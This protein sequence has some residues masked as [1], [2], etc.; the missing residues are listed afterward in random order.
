MNMNGVRRH[1]IMSSRKEGECFT[2]HFTKL[3]A[4]DRQ[5]N[6]RIKLV[7]GKCDMND[8]AACFIVP[9]DKLDPLMTFTHSMRSKR[10]RISYLRTM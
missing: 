6:W 4:N 10:C 7:P 2:Y 5:G 3:W 9:T 1:E 8:Q